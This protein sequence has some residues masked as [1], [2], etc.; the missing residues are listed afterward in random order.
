MVPIIYR[1]VNASVALGVGL[2]IIFGYFS[3]NIRFL[4]TMVAAKFAINAVFGVDEK[5]FRMASQNCR[6]GFRGSD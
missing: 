2:V 1:A 3:P 4:T 5:W 6:D